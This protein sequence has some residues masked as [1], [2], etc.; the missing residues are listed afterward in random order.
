MVGSSIGDAPN[1]VGYKA[2]DDGLVNAEAGNGDMLGALLLIGLERVRGG[3]T[4]KIQLGRLKGVIDQAGAGDSYEG[5]STDN[6]T[7]HME[8]TVGGVGKRRKKSR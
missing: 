1:V 6:N 4:G 8:K 7:V 5:K 3:R 2:G